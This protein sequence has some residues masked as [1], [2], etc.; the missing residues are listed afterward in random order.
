MSASRRAP[1]ITDLI[2][3]PATAP[4]RLPASPP[5]SLDCPIEEPVAAAVEEVSPTAAS[6]AVAEPPPLPH[7][8]LHD[9]AVEDYQQLEQWL[10][11]LYRNAAQGRF[12]PEGIFDDAAAIAERPALLEALFAETFRPREAGDVFVRAAL[13]TTIY[14]LRLGAGLGYAKSSLQELGV[15]G[16][17]HKVGV[18]RLPPEIVFAAKPLDSKAAAALREHPKL[19]RDSIRALGRRFEGV[20]EVIYQSQE[21]SD[22][23]GYPLALRGEQ[24]AE[25]SLVLGL[26]AVFEA[27]TQPRVYRPRMTPFVAV[28]EILQQERARFPRN[29]LRQFFISFSGFPPFSYVRLSSNAVAQVVASDALNPLR[30]SVVVVRDAAGRRTS[31]NETL[32]LVEHPSLHIVGPVSEAEAR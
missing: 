18:V 2:R 32:R 13:N 19:A 27:M 24:I 8:V 25:P 21:R 14:A 4:A 11:R 17:L 29:V 16:M 23:S 3:Q 20:A 12:D 15:A 7:P 30:P 10:G 5:K 28:K 6:T 9:D 22:G 26:A 1:R 31:S